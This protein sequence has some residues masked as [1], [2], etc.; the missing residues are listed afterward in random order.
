MKVKLNPV[1]CYLRDRNITI[2]ESNY[3]YF[4]PQKVFFRGRVYVDL[5]VNLFIWL[6][7]LAKEISAWSCLWLCF[8]SA[9]L[10]KVKVIP[11][12]IWNLRGPIRKIFVLLH[13]FSSN[14]VLQVMI[15]INCMHF[16]NKLD[17][18][19]KILNRKANRHKS[20]YRWDDTYLPLFST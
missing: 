11:S 17:F 6:S 12:S 3:Y 2:T 4:D 8:W 9:S 15:F 16:N 7:C 13:S 18:F 19:C 10:T 14:Y 1:H 5:S 20:V